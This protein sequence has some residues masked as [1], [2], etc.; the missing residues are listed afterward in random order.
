MDK[1]GKNRKGVQVLHWWCEI[2]RILFTQQV[3]QEAVLKLV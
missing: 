1:F 2:E 3:N